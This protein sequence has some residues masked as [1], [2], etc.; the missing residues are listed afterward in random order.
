MKKLRPTP[1]YTYNVILSGETR[2]RTFME[3][4]VVDKTWSAAVDPRQRRDRSR[5][6]L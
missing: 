6:P 3:G 5:L 4:N 1:Y 2:A